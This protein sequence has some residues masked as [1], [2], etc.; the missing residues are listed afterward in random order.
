MVTTDAH[1]REVYCLFVNITGV[2]VDVSRYVRTGIDQMTFVGCPCDQLSFKENRC[3]HGPIADMRVTRKRGIVDDDIPFTNVVS[4]GSNHEPES[5]IHGTDVDG[6]AV[7][8][9]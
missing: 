9:R 4:E 3:E 2:K 1:T 7:L 5:G 8:H 6:N